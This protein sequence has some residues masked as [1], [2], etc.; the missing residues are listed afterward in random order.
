VRRAL[1]D[2]RE[3]PLRLAARGTHITLF[4]QAEP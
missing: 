2:I 4:E 1:A 3:V